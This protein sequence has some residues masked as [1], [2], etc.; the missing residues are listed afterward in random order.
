MTVPRTLGCGMDFAAEGLLDGLDDERARAERVALLE[1]L[2]ADGVPL[3]ELSE[4]VAEDRLVFLRVE[5]TLGTAR[6]TP[7]EVARADGDRRRGGAALPPGARPPP[8]G[9]STSAC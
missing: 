7:R 3:E 1:E 4:A 8:P 5:R 6:Y 9:R 2:L